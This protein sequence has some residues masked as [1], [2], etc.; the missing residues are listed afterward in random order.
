VALQK[1]QGAGAPPPNKAPATATA[2]LPPEKPW[3][4]RGEMR[5]VFANLREIVG[6]I[7][8][9]CE[10]AKSGVKDPSEFRRGED[11][12]LCYLRLLAIADKEAA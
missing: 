4:N 10:M 1:L 5:K 7:A 8:Y 9:G 11:A 3:T 6:E 2:P 12:Q